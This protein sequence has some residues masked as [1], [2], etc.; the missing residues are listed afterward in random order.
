MLPRICTSSDPSAF[1]ATR[2]AGPMGAE[3]PIAG[4]LGDQHAALVGQA[5]FAPGEAK[6]TYGTGNFMLLNT[7]RD[8]VPSA[9]G[10]LTT[11]C[12]QIG[13]S[14]TIYAL[15]GSIAV[16]RSAVPWLRDQLGIISAAASIEALANRAPRKPRRLMDQLD[17]LTRQLEQGYA[18]A[19]QK[20]VREQGS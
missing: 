16:T 14:D 8:I 19:R 2:A 3:V 7:G 6:N 9:S 17:A 13:R 20:G 10:L 1:G 15:E 5:C 11:V 4:D 12:Y 18:D